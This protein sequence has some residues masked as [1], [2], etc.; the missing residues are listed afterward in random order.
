MPVSSRTSRAAQ[1]SRDSPKLRKPAARLYRP[2]GHAAFLTS[3]ISSSRL[4]ITI[5]QGEIRENCL[6]LHA[7]HCLPHSRENNVV[8]SP[9]TGQKRLWCSQCRIC[10]ARP[11]IPNVALS[12]VC[13]GALSASAIY[14]G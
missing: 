7:E 10:L 13:T 1:S 9:H 4:T 8:I 3:R 11:L 6:A 2:S 12:I 5:A 14:G